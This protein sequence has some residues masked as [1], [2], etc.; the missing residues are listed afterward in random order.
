MK[1]IST[2]NTYASI[3]RNLEKMGIMTQK[4]I[5]KVYKNEE[6]MPYMNSRIDLS[7][8]EI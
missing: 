6:R 8:P 1:D 3:Q 5:R 4:P 7:F 2:L